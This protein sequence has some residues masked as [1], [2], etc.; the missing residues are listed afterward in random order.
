MHNRMIDRMIIVVDHIKKSMRVYAFTDT[1]P[2]STCICSSSSFLYS[3]FHFEEFITAERIAAKH[4][5][6]D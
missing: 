1:L 2:K 6:Y 3:Y 4:D 5:L